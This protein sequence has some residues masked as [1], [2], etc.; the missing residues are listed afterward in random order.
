L[1]TGNNL[2][3]DLIGLRFGVSSDNGD[4]F[5]KDFEGNSD[6]DQVLDNLEYNDLDPW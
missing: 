1:Y 4:G 2:V 6:L 5:L 3:Q